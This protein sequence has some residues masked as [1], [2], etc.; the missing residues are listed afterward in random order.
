MSARSVTGVFVCLAAF[1]AVTVEATPGRYLSIDEFLVTAFDGTEPA[2]S[3]IVVDS[4]LRARMEKILDHRFAGIRI[5]YWHDGRTTAWV[6]EEIGKTEPITIGVAVQDATVKLVRVLE[7]RESRGW[8][9]RYPFFTGQFEG[10]SMT[11]RLTLDRPVDGI[12]GATL[13]VSAV[14]KVVRLALLLDRYV[15]ADRET[16]APESS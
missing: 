2:P 14:D 7:F 10:M 3:R 4:D 13:S 8:E 5:R 16:G 6:L 1:A 9:I 15:H 12:T 11:D